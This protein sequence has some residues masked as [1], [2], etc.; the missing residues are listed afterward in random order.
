MREFISFLRGCISVD[1]SAIFFAL[2][3]SQIF[4][5]SDAIFI[6]YNCIVNF[7]VRQV[8]GDVRQKKLEKERGGRGG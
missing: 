7:W 8:I 3:M 1:E 4:I 5:V 2:L 6:S